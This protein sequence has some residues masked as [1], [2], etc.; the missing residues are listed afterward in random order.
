MPKLPSQADTQF[1]KKMHNALDSVLDEYNPWKGALSKSPMTNK[2]MSLYQKI[3]SKDQTALYANGALVERLPGVS[4][5]KACKILKDY[6]KAHPNIEVYLTSF[7]GGK[8][9]VMVSGKY[10]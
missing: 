4:W 9:N 10:L 3:N 7:S 6:S 8:T 1:R 2:E 5:T